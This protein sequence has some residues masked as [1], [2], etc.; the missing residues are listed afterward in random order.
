MTNGYI[1]WMVAVA[2]GVITMLLVEQAFRSTDPRLIVPFAQSLGFWLAWLVAWP[3]AH[4]HGKVRRDFLYYLLAGG[5]PC[6]LIASV[7][8]AFIHG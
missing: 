6:W 2:T 1:A 3:Y 8:M 5:M 7:R 4:A